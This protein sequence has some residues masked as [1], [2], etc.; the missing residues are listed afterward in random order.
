MMINCYS[1]TCLFLL[2][3][4]LFSM[5]YATE[6]TND[7]RE[8]KPLNDDELHDA[9][10]QILEELQQ[11]E[12]ALKHLPPDNKSIGNQV[13]WVRALNLQLINPR[14]RISEDEPMPV[15]DVDI[16]MPDTA[17]QPMVRFPHKAH[18][19]WLDCSN[20]HPSPF[21]K[22]FNAN[23]I[24]MLTILQG[25]YCGRC[26]GAVSFPLTECRRCHSVLRENFKGS[27]GPQPPPAKIFPPVKEQKA[28]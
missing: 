8:W 20:C 28:Q 14:S 23:P 27:V 11:P 24:D 1:K 13:D 17:G 5:A 4:A 22:E 25:K 18:T 19:D 12:E 26:H 3:L 15:W 9:S 10:N 16:I 2:L 7:N 21:I 6:K